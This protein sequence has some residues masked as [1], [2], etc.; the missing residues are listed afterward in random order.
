[1]MYKSLLLQKAFQAKMN[2]NT[3]IAAKRTKVP[4]ARI[5]L[6]DEIGVKR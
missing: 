4:E 5:M 2:L 3:E 1:M 6:L